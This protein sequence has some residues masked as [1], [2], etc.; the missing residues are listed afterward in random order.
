[1]LRQDEDE[2][3]ARDGAD[4]DVNALLCMT[5]PE[6]VRICS[7]LTGLEFADCASEFWEGI[8]VETYLIFASA[9]A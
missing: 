4:G 9:G 2:G 7:V 5:L 1:V 6:Y 8:G 3:Q